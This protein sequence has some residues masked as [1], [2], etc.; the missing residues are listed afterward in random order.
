MIRWSINAPLMSFSWAAAGSYCY[1]LLT[2]FIPLTPSSP[3]PHPPYSPSL[4]YLQGP[5]GNQVCLRG[6]TFC[7]TYFYFLIFCLAT[8]LLTTFPG[9]YYELVGRIVFVCFHCLWCL[10]VLIIVFIAGYQCSINRLHRGTPTHTRAD[11][12]LAGVPR[13]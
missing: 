2:P 13:V 4:H 10:V 8:N 11:W 5:A 9:N 6:D 7:L 3:H 12:S 1:T